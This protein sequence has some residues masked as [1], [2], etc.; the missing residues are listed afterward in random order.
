M[1]P[2]LR[3]VSGCG[4]LTLGVVALLDGVPEVGAVEV[5]V[6][7]RDDL[8]L[9]PNQAGLALEGLPVPLDKSGVSVVVDKPVG[10]DA[11]PVLVGRISTTSTCPVSTPA[12]YHEPVATRNAIAGH[13]VE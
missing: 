11:E 12:T 2:P 9:L 3:P 6:S 5:G 4:W 13:G 1:C 10:V 8:G 7:A